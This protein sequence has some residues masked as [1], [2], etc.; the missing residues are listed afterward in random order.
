MALCLAIYVGMTR[1]RLEVSPQGISYYSLGYRVVTPWDNVAGI[2]PVHAGQYT[3]E[4]L[5]LREPRLE[6]GE[7]LRTGT[8]LYPFM[9]IIA[10]AEGAR[11]P[12]RRTGGL[13]AGDSAG[14]VCGAVGREYAGRGDSLLSPALTAQGDADTA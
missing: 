2:G 4:G 10:Y 8:A 13:Y 9:A 11:C 6:A 5:L 12:P 14:V 3:Y 1:V 7:W